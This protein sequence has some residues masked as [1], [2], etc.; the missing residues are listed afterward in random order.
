MYSLEG[1]RGGVLGIAV[2]PDD[3]LVLSGGRDGTVRLWDLAKG[4]A[5]KV[6]EGHR[7]WVEDLASGQSLGEIAHGDWVYGLACSPDGKAAYSAGSG[8]NV[9]CWDLST[10]E[11][12]AELNGHEKA[13][14]AVAVSPDG[15]LLVT[16]SSDTTLLVWQAPGD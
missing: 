2:S 3:K 1:H 12:T 11:R 14:N 9:A 7:G 15:K 6:L 10:G 4:E 8:P 16:A 13:A 5:L